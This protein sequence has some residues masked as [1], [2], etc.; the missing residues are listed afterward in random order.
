LRELEASKK[1][2]LL[3]L[4]FQVGKAEAIRRGL[5][6]LLREKDI[7]AV[8]QID[9]RQKQPPEDV[10]VLIDCFKKSGADMVVANRYAYKDKK[11]DRHRITISTTLAGIIKYFTGIDI[12]D[13]ACG[14]RIYRVKLARQFLQLRSF[15]YGLEAEQL[16]IASL[17]KA[18]VIH[19]PIHSKPQE[20]YTSAEKIE[21][22]LIALLAYAKE[23]SMNNDAKATLSYFLFNIKQRNIFN[24]NLKAIGIDKQ[25]K[26]KP[27]TSSGEW[28]YTL[29]FET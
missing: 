27:V 12:R 21:D 11:L 23:L 22:N 14:M 20:I 8:V 3:V 5:I 28:G 18:Q 26:G 4:P 9:G 6:R 15:G 13:A 25:I 2:R 17:N 7:D 1:I 19:A 10:S 16:I 29:S 24:C